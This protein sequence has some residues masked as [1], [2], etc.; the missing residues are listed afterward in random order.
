MCVCACVRVCVRACVCVLR[1]HTYDLLLCIEIRTCICVSYREQL[2]KWFV[3]LQL[4]DY[5]VAFH[6]SEEVGL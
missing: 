3:D 1:K 4:S 5:K 6:E 2:I